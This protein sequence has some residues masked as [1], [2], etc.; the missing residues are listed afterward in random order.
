VGE[1]FGTTFDAAD[2]FFRVLT[3]DQ[4]ILQQACLLRLQT[5]RGTLWTDPEY[6]DAIAEILQDGLTAASFG[7]I[8]ERVRAELEKD[9]RIGSV[10]VAA[11]I[12]GAPGSYAVI[13]AITVRPATGPEFALTISVSSVSVEVL[14]KGS[15]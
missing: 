12:G 7:R 13:L 15:V 11:T 1:L 3:D 9:E 10:G 8:P 14:E 5:A 2:P 6:G 4:A